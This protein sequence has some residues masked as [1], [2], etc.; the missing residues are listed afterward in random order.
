MRAV[1]LTL[2][3]RAGQTGISS[4]L[5][6]PRWGFCNVLFHGKGVIL[7]RELG[8]WVI[9]NVFFKVVPAEGHALSA[10]EAMLTLRRHLLA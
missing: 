3:T 5:S 1:Y 7:P 9:E 10:I 6:A 8:N 2:L 4:A